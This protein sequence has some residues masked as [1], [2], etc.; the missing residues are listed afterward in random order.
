LKNLN[1]AHGFAANSRPFVVGEVIA[2]YNLENDGFLGSDYFKLGTITEF[3]YS[4]EISRVFSGNEL[5]KYLTNFGEG[6]S[7]WQSQY[8][9]TFVGRWSSAFFC[10]LA[11]YSHTILSEKCH[12]LL[13]LP[14]AI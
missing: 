3:R 2:G 7:F 14:P 8:A 1:T 5:L 4:Q 10:L 12:L 13:V 9:L 11:P 6:W